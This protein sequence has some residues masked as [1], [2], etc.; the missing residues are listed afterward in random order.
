[1]AV[2]ACATALL[3][4]TAPPGGRFGRHSPP[5]APTQVSFDEVTKV[6]HCAD[7]YGTGPLPPEGH[8]ALFVQLPDT[9]SVYYET[10]LTFDAAGWV[11]DDVTLGEVDDARHFT[12]YLYAVTAE[13]EQ[14]LKDLPP[15]HP[16]ELM[17]RRLLDVLIVI[18][19]DGPDTC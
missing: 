12:L 15:H 17:P 11:A 16:L 14:R 4:V 10:A 13:A 2:A 19:D 5:A 6:P 1:M 18:R 8:A 7:Y 9:T 3:L